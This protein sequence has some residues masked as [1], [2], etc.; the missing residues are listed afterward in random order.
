MTENDQIAHGKSVLSLAD[1]IRARMREHGWS[2]RDLERHS[3]RVLTRGRWQQLGSGGPQKKF[4]DPA[5]LTAIAG[6]LQLDITL[7]V[8]AAAQGVGLAVQH[9][10]SDLARL[11]PPGTEQLSEQMRNAI[12]TMISAAIAEAATPTGKT[13]RPGPR[14]GTM[15]WSKSDAPSQR[16][17]RGTDHSDE[18]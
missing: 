1:L 14:G 18:G 5:S 17:R 16:H 13:D 12:L 8:L 2:Y 3:G 4:P 10:G 9:P 7:V 6:A 11:L 15:E